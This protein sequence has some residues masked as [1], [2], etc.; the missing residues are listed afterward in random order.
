[1]IYKILKCSRRLFY[2]LQGFRIFR[3]FW[4][5]LQLFKRRNSQLKLPKTLVSSKLFLMMKNQDQ[6]CQYQRFPSAYLARIKRFY[7]Q[8][9]QQCLHFLHINSILSDSSRNC[10]KFSIKALLKLRHLKNEVFSLFRTLF[11]RYY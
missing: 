3:M 5:N 9:Y 7:E 2:V 8:I 10:N 1:V 4:K 11:I 6:S